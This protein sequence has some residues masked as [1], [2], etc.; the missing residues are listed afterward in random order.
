MKK[1]ES[2]QDSELL[3]EASM[4]GAS[5][6]F[7]ASVSLHRQRKRCSYLTQLRGE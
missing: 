7:E 6:H 1:M 3:K 2:L 4:N 5:S